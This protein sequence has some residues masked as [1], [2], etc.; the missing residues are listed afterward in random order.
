VEFGDGGDQCGVT[1]QGQQACAH[2]VAQ[3]GAQSTA[4]TDGLQLL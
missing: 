1:S 4:A 2:Y 3:S